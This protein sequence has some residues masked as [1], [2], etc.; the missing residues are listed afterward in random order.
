MQMVS[1]PRQF[2]V[3]VMPNLYGDIVNN[4]ASGLIG[5]AGVVAGA[6]YSANCVVYET[7]LYSIYNLFPTLCWPEWIA[8]LGFF[9]YFLGSCGQ[10]RSEPDGYVAFFV[11]HAQPRRLGILRQNDSECCGEGPQNWQGNVIYWIAAAFISFFLFTRVFQSNELPSSYWSSTKFSLFFL[12]SAIR[13][14]LSM[15]IPVM[16]EK[17]KKKK[18]GGCC[19]EQLWV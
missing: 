6:S 17:K 15:L 16:M 7:V 3:M 5:G 9:S 18:E 13:I 14:K 10:K 11:Q 2:D 4:V 19:R 1:N 12:S 8:P